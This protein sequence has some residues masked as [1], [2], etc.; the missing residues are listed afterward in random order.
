[1][2]FELG[3]P[4]I[5]EPN[6]VTGVPIRQTRRFWKPEWGQALGGILV[7]RQGIPIRG[8]QRVGRVYHVNNRRYARGIWWRAHGSE[9]EYAWEGNLDWAWALANKEVLYRENFSPLRV[10]VTRLR[11]QDVRAIAPEEAAFEGMSVDGF[12]AYWASKYDPHPPEP[13][14][15]IEHYFKRDSNLYRALVVE[16]E[17]YLEPR[18]RPYK[19]KSTGRKQ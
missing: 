19:K 14:R 3:W 15:G 4:Y 11:E 5:L 16:I 13:F 1:M 2:I 10:I 17:P 9:I 6:P 7:D 12:L 8:Y 18:K